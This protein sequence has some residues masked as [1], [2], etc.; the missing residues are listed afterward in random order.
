MNIIDTVDEIRETTCYLK[1]KFEMK[2]LG[3][4]WFCVAT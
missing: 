4:T 3:K 2:G 1:S